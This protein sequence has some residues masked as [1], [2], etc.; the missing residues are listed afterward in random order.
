MCGG[1]AFTRADARVGARQA[2]RLDARRAQRRDEPRIYETRQHAD[3]DIERGLVGDAQ[4]VDLA[5]LDAGTRAS[6]ASISRPPP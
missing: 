3:D 5:L 6:A 2:D 4:P 1:A